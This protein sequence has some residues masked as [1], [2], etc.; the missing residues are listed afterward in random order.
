MLRRGD[1]STPQSNWNFGW[2]VAVAIVAVIGGVLVLAAMGKL[3]EI[4]LLGV[5]LITSSPPQPS[6]LPSPVIDDSIDQP[7]IQSSSISPTQ[8]VVIS[9][10]TPSPTSESTGV[11]YD[12]DPSSPYAN[13]RSSPNL[14][15][16]ILIEVPNGTPVTILEESITDGRVWYKVQVGGQTGWIASSLR[17]K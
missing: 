3:Q 4:E 16:N 14:S 7:S 9:P 1:V 6:P 12:S 10:L 5:R 17:R 15:D 13:L 11:V 8:P 2:P